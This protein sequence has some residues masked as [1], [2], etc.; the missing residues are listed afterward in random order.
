MN[1]SGRHDMSTSS[2]GTYDLSTELTPDKEGGMR[3]K[4]KQIESV[5]EKEEDT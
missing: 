2:V 4:N 5:V 3:K 1:D